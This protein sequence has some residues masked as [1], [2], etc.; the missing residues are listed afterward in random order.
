MVSRTAF[1][2]CFCFLLLRVSSVVVVVAFHHWVKLGVGQSLHHLM[3]VIVVVEVLGSTK[4]FGM[5]NDVVVVCLS[6]GQSG[7]HHQYLFCAEGL[8]K[9]D[10]V[11]A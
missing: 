3:E 9:V 2:W 1:S 5:V 4:G 8:E 6:V 10:G 7:F 11:M